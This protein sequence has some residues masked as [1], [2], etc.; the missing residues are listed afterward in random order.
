MKSGVFINPSTKTPFLDNFGTSTDKTISQNIASIASAYSF[1]NITNTI[2]FKTEPGYLN[3]N[4]VLQQIGD[5]ITLSFTIKDDLTNAKLYLYA[6][7]LADRSTDW[8]SFV[9]FN[10]E[11]E[12]KF[13]GPDTRLNTSSYNSTIIE[14]DKTDIVRGDVI[15]VSVS[16]SVGNAIL[17]HKTESRENAIT[18]LPDSEEFIQNLNQW[19]GKRIVWIG[20]SIPYGVTY[21]KSQSNPMANPYPKQLEELLGCTVLNHAQAGMSIRYNKD[22]SIRYG[23]CLSLSIAELQ[24]KGCA[25]TPFKSYENAILGFNADLYVFDSEPNNELS[26]G[27]L[28]LL[29]MFNIKNWAYS[30]NSSF[31]SHRDT[32]AGAFIYIYDKL[33][34]EKPDAKVVLV[35]EYGG[36]GVGYGNGD[37]WETEYYIHTVNLAIARKFNLPIISL[38]E[39]LGYNPKNVDIYMNGDRVHPKYAAHVRI[40]NILKEKLLEVF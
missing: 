24:E 14:I 11:G 1:R 10:S 22:G 34:T 18:I 21:E 7:G 35:G 19:K 27:D 2:E 26:E 36:T 25:T 28:E 16:K 30:D 5:G 33:L 3:T 8:A 20:T 23:Q 6:T 37:E 13:I 9:V 15:K 4:G 38:F 39:L 12:I 17:F 40:A 31:E 32:F 29:N